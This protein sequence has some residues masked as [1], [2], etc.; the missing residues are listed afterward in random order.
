[1]LQKIQA[2]FMTPEYVKQVAAA[3]IKDISDRAENITTEKSDQSGGPTRTTIYQSG[4]VKKVITKKDEMIEYCHDSEGRVIREETP[5]RVTEYYYG[6]NGDLARSINTTT[7]S[8]TDNI[9]KDGILTSIK[10]MDLFHRPVFTEITTDEL[11]RIIKTDNKWE[12]VTCKFD[13]GARKVTKTCVSKVPN[14]K[15]YTE[16]CTYDE[17]GRLVMKVRDGRVTRRYEYNGYIESKESTKIGKKPEFTEYTTI[18]TTYDVP[19]ESK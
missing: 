19:G 4:L 9:Y 11:G 7:G 18:R 13:D 12:T 16:E 3:T 14:K 15:G 5:S 6:K 8:V 1:M 2:K 17:Y 10:L